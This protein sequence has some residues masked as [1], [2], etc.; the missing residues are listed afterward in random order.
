MKILGPHSH[1][2]KKENY[3]KLY[4]NVFVLVSGNKYTLF[5]L[6]YVLYQT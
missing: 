4:V 5:A 1:P 6:D 3:L 2:Y